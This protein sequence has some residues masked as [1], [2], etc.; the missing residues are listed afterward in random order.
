MTPAKFASGLTNCLKLVLVSRSVGA[1]DQGIG[2]TD[3]QRVQR[4]GFRTGQCLNGWLPS[5]V[6]VFTAAMRRQST[7]LMGY[8]PHR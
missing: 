1:A 5:A 6:P 8:R 4:I 7:S 2:T 3:E